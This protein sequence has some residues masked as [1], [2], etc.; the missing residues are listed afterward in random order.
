M[1]KWLDK[2]KARR[3][4]G[5]SSQGKDRGPN[6]GAWEKTNIPI[7]KDQGFKTGYSDPY[8]GYTR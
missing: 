7:K 5:E 6:T 1:A 2:Q 3:H 8:R 4:K